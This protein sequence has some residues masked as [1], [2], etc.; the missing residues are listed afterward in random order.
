LPAGPWYQPAWTDAHDNPVGIAI[1][2]DDAVHEIPQAVTHRFRGRRVQLFGLFGDQDLTVRDV[3]AAV[4]RMP[5]DG[6]GRL[7]LTLPGVEITQLAL[8]LSGRP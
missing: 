4:G 1:A 8:A 5:V 7:R 6:W 2:A 3:E